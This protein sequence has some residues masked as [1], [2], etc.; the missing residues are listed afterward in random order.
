MARKKQITDEIISKYLEPIK[1]RKPQRIASY[2]TVREF[3]TNSEYSKNFI[4]TIGHEIRDKYKLDRAIS[5]LGSLKKLHIYNKETFF[6]YYPSDK[7]TDIGTAAYKGNEDDL[8]GYTAKV[9]ELMSKHRARGEKDIDLTSVLLYM[10]TIF[11][12]EYSSPKMTTCMKL[13]TPNL[14]TSGAP[15]PYIVNIV[16]LWISQRM[17]EAM[18]LDKKSWYWPTVARFLTCMND[19]WQQSSSV[20]YPRVNLIVPVREDKRASHL[21]YLARTFSM[22]YANTKKVFKD[23]IDF[24]E[25]SPEMLTAL[26]QM[27]AMSPSK[28]DTLDY[29]GIIQFMAGQEKKN[30]LFTYTQPSTL[31]NYFEAGENI[32]RSVIK[33]LDIKPIFYETDG[34]LNDPFKEAVHIGIDCS[35]I[36]EVEDIKGYAHDA[37]ALMLLRIRDYKWGQGCIPKMFNIDTQML[38][39]LE[40]VKNY[41]TTF[42]TDVKKFEKEMNSFYNRPIKLRI[43]YD[44]ATATSKFGEP[45]IKFL[46][47]ISDIHTDVNKDRNYV[48][49][50]GNDFVINCGDTSGDCETTRAWIR[51]YMR[52]GVV[53]AGNHMGYTMPHPEL[54]GPHNIKNWASEI[55]PK[56]TKNGQVDYLRNCFKRGNVRFL[57]NDMMEFQD[58]IIIGNTLYTDFKLFGE[59]NQPACAMEA[60]RCMNDFRN[61]YFLY[62]KKDHHGKADGFVKEYTTEF[63]VRQFNACIGYIKNR[64]NYL[65]RHKNK[66]PIIIVT[67]HIPVPYGV[68]KQY[69]NDPLSAAFASDLRDFID[70]YPEIRL[71]CFGHTHHPFDFIY[72][73]TR[74][75]CEPW[76]YFNE[77][78][79]DIEKY[80][81][82]IPIKQ[83]KSRK[84]W[85]YL[86]AAKIRNYEVKY[87]S[88]AKDEREAKKAAKLS[89]DV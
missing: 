45:E 52:D 59:K 26:A 65:R 39:T 42:V 66:K 87:Y 88:R 17:L 25:T 27:Q 1:K 24:T 89:K 28:V 11:K 67:H 32:P 43:G 83:V 57:S 48:F 44:Y 75:V 53:V 23:V 22:S 10:S 70:E 5:V 71:W 73:N 15:N 74:F 35:E 34:L 29:A 58:M 84:Q 38:I 55:D 78:G 19:L 12:E 62:L 49:D 7:G 69:Q 33:R 18:G 63:H 41:T 21:R 6:E 80:G 20:S 50:F 13:F 9:L 36:E 46:R 79:F 30:K 54:N 77:N 68:E 31:F 8:I 81:K 51:S 72:N 16:H 56:N 3:F 86:L 47:V 64:L 61:S 14:I 85:R 82:R 2:S 76:G 4:S 40:N 37:V 60:A